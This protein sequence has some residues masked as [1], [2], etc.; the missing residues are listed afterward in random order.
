M[1]QRVILGLALVARPE[2]LLHPLTGGALVVA[3]TLLLLV[4]GVMVVT[5]RAVAPIWWR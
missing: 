3:Y 2:G 4:A 1:G 5:R